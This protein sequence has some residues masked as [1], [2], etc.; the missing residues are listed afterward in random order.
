MTKKDEQNYALIQNDLAYIKRDIAE[1][2]QEVTNGY[3]TRT[4]FEPIKK[5]VYGLVGII[6]VSFAGAVVSL[7]IRT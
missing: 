3:V 6:L 2:K 5:L 4:E 1:I 7:V